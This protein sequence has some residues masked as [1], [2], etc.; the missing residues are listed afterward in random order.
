[1][2]QYKEIKP[3]ELSNNPFQLIGKDWMLVTAKK[4]DA[5]NTMTASWGGMGVMWNKNIAVTVLRPQRYTKEFIDASDRFSLSFYDDSYKKDMTYV[6]RVSGREEPDKIEK[7]SFTPTEIDG[8]PYFKEANLVF[9][10]KKLFVQEM[11]PDGFVDDC[12][13]MD[14]ANYPN[15]DY[16]FMYVAEIEKILVKEI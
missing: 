2:A 14:A 9:I 11:N 12:K 3:E 5:I 13:D 4:G 8:V 16:H 7:T 1:M 10:C 6:G 15:K